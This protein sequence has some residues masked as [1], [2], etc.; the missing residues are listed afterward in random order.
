MLGTGYEQQAL[1]KRS[2]AEVLGAVSVIRQVFVNRMTRPTIQTLL[3][4]AVMVTVA[5][6][7]AVTTLVCCN[8]DRWGGSVNPL[9]IAVMSFFG[10]LTVPLWPTYIPAIVFT[11]LLMRWVAG[12][13][14][15]TT[16]PIPLVLV[17]STLIGAV[18]GVC[19]LSYVVLLSLKGSSTMVL[20]WLTAG[21]IS[22][23]FTLSVICLIYRYAPPRG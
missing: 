12:R 19:V 2:A 13:R 20:G 8:P 15:F 11:P 10:L 3:S 21:S 7:V 22:G 17:L 5:P 18:A 16:L 6:V 4:V 9:N 23:G 14:D 1:D